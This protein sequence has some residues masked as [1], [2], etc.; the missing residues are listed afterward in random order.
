MLE[1]FWGSLSR[2]QYYLTR[3]PDAKATTVTADLVPYFP[4]YSH[5]DVLWDQLIRVAG[6]RSAAM[7][8]S[9]ANLKMVK[10]GRLEATVPVRLSANTHLF[11][12]E[13]GKKNLT[14]NSKQ[15]SYSV[16][17]NVWPSKEPQL[18]DNTSSVSEQDPDPHGISLIGSPVTYQ[19]RRFSFHYLMVVFL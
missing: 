16:E 17:I 19:I 11:I 6:D 1:L 7:R 12:N 4:Y 3:S 8:G 14:L 18:T 15:G 10:N 5:R 2:H 13:L 9:R